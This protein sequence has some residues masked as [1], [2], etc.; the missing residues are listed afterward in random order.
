MNMQM[1]GATAVVNPEAAWLGHGGDEVAVGVGVCV[2][3]ESG[4]FVIL[5]CP[6]ALPPSLP[7]P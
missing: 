2:S 1:K 4:V 3:E 7:S 5:L 6:P